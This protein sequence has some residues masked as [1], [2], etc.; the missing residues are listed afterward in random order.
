MASRLSTAKYVAQRLIRNAAQI[1]YTYAVARRARV[2]GQSVVLAASFAKVHEH[3]A[4]R[5]S[6]SDTQQHSDAQQHS[7][8]QPTDTIVKLPKSEFI[9]RIMEGDLEL[10]LKAAEDYEVWSTDS[11]TAVRF[12]CDWATYELAVARY[13]G[14]VSKK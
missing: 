14:V 6:N 3:H 11:S 8:T 12:T 9:S 5:P 13:T 2:A 7:D 10:C 4:N 1:P